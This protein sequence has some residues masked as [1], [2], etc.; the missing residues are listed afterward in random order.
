[1]NKPIKLN[2]Y[3]KRVS[4]QKTEKGWEVYFLGDDGRKRPACDL[5]IPSFITE[6]EIEGYL[7]D[8]CHEWSTDKNKDVYKLS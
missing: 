5:A 8:I 1:M 3:G 2:V 4:A 7:S 6:D